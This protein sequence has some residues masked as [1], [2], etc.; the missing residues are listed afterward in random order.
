MKDRLDEFYCHNH[1]PDHK[2]FLDVIK[3]LVEIMENRVNENVPYF[4]FNFMDHYTHDYL[5][6]P[7]SYDFYLR[8]LIKGLEDRGYLDNT[9]FILFS[10]H[11]NRMTSYSDTDFGVLEKTNPFVSLRLPK[12]LRD[13]EYY[14]NARHNTRKMVTPFD[15]YKTMQQ[16]YYINKYPDE[17]IDNSEGYNSR[18]CREYFAKSQPQVRSQRGVSVFEKLS[19]NRTCT[20]ALVTPGYCNCKNLITINNETE[21]K[22]QTGLSFDQTAAYVMAKINEIA[23]KVRDKCE[24]FRLDKV[25]GVTKIIRRNMD[26]LAYKIDLLCQPAGAK[27]DVMFKI[28]KQSSTPLELIGKMIRANRYGSQSDCVSSES[29]KYSGFCYCK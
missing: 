1:I 25:E 11:G 28:N 12:A 2:R 6:I 9:L 18:K 23:D 21:Y 17:L 10:D 22:E 27:F 4:S 3:N 8:D 5:T 16:F 24:P 7:D 15:F 29:D 19:F 14:Q 26:T 20:E 13:T